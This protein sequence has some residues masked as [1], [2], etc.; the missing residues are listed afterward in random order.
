MV[1]SLVTFHCED[2]EGYHWYMKFLKTRCNFTVDSRCDRKSKSEIKSRNRTNGNPAF[3]RSR[4]VDEQNKI[5]LQKVY[6][7]GI[8]TWLTKKV[9][10]FLNLWLIFD[11]ELELDIKRT[12]AYVELAQFPTRVSVFR[13][14]WWTTE[15]LNAFNEQKISI[16]ANFNQKFVWTYYKAQNHIFT[17]G[18]R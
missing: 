7:R 1:I 12:S 11:K 17:P 13:S 9:N 2:F 6:F 10:F 14:L 16:N 8:S 18:S 5:L 3:I 4:L 15:A